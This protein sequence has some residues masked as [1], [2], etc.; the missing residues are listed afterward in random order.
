MKVSLKGPK[1][2]GKFHLQHGVVFFS[3][4]TLK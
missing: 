1:N 2:L 4:V 3:N